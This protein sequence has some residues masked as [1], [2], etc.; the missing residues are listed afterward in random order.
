MLAAGFI[1]LREGFEAAL[2]VGIV[3]GFL[4]KIGHLENRRTVWWGVVSAAAASLV[5]A[6]GL[7]WLGTEF[8]GRAEEIFEGVVMLLAA[9]VLTCM[10]FWI[11]A[12]RRHL[13]GRLETEV[14]DAVRTGADSAS[15]GLAFL[16]VFREG[17]ETALFLS[18]P[19]FSSSPIETSAGGLL[20][21]AAAVVI[22]W[23]LFMTS[24]GLDIR[25]FFRFTGLLMIVFAA[26]L[27]AHGI[28]ELQEAA[29]LPVLVA[30]AFDINPILSE[31]SFV[32]SVL[33]SSFGYNGNPSLLEVIS[34]A[35]CFLALW[36]ATRP[37]EPA[38]DHSPA[39]RDVL[40]L[41][42]RKKVQA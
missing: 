33:K 37:K 8:E 2:I 31:N 28:H 40:A 3:L 27:V 25:S 21:L 17:V 11:Q 39:Q 6:L 41:L 19:A 42:S 30:H 14:Q 24:T 4:R 13:K 12:Q 16:A 29:L 26:G 7:Q 18:A 36:L 32:G 35:A 22:G 23:L 38:A 5:V 10:I 9:G 15:F 1:T 20:G 34:Y